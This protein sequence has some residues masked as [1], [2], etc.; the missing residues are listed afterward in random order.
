MIAISNNS[1]PKQ[2]NITTISEDSCSNS[3]TVVHH[4]IKNK[5]I[6]IM[7]YYLILKKIKAPS[8]TQMPHLTI[9][10]CK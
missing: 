3:I 10:I 4:Q 9:N 7:G 6:T 1:L 8:M 5:M 2:D